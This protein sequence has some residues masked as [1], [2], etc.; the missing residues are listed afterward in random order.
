LHQNHPTQPTNFYTDITKQTVVGRRQKKLHVAIEL[1][2][3]FTTSKQLLTPP[4]LSHQIR[5]SFKVPNTIK[6]F[7][8]SLLKI[9]SADTEQA[10]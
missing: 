5:S 4:L 10:V 3:K 8:I 1:L 6:H 9:N 2:S 7:I